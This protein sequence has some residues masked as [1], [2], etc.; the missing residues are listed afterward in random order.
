MFTTNKYVSIP[1]VLTID[2]CE[3]IHQLM[4]TKKNTGLLTQEDRLNEVR[5]HRPGQ[6]CSYGKLNIPECTALSVSLTERMES[7][8]G[9]RMISSDTYCRIYYNNSILPKHHDREGL[10]YTLSVTIFNNLSFDW[11][12]WCTD[13]NGND[14]AI[15]IPQG[16]G[17]MMLGR[18]LVH[19]RD[20]LQCNPDQYVVQLFLHWSKADD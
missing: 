16:D 5:E 18:T 9:V 2:Q 14:I 15:S 20:K 17:A 10:D 1:Q 12:L 4:V 7:L 3:N 19:W 11:P 8:L 13:L 6:G